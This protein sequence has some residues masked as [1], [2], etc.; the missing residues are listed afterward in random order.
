VIGEAP[1]DQLS[2]TG[3]RNQANCRHIATHRV[4]CRH[5]VIQVSAAVIHRDIR[6]PDLIVDGGQIIGRPPSRMSAENAPLLAPVQP[7]AGGLV[8]QIGARME[9]I[10]Y[11][12]FMDD[13][14][15]MATQVA[16]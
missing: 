10:P 12:V 6:R 5:A 14:W 4:F 3:R 9:L 16:S 11:A 15:I 8:G 2:H 1:R 7:V 13:G